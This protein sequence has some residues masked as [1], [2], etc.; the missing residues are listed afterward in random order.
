[1]RII[2]INLNHCEVAHSLLEQVLREKRAD[3]ALI[4]EPYKKVETQSYILDSSKTAAIW[5]GRQPESVQPRQF[6]H[7]LDEI[8]QDARHRSQVVIAG[9][10]NAWSEDWGSTRTNAR[11]RTLQE[12]FATLDVALLNTGSQNTF[13]KAGY[14][15]I[16]DLTFCSSGLYRRTTWSLSN[17]YTASDHKYIVCDLEDREQAPTAARSS[18]FNPASL[19]PLK[20]AEEL[21]IPDPSGDVECEVHNTMAAVLQACRASMRCSRGHSR[22]HEP[23]P[24]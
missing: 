19:Q 9:D 6:T 20:F 11:G 21:R 4:S 13:S 24:W 7:I 15:S 18:R 8:A 22:H 2:Q 16:V 10:F 17:D 14:G 23:V 1:M 12:T 5:A 3:I